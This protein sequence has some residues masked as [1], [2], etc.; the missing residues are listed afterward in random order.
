M[1]YFP[2]DKEISLTNKLIQPLKYEEENPEKQFIKK[3]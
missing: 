1:G 3:K 2:I